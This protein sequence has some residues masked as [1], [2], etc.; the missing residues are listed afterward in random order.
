HAPG[1]M[2]MEAIAVLRALRHIKRDGGE[3]LRL[4][5]EVVDRAA[6]FTRLTKLVGESSVWRSLTPYLH[7]WHL[8]KPDMRSPEALRAAIL[9][10]L[11]R[12]WLA[13]DKELP[14]IVDVSE[15]SSLSFGGRALRAI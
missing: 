10:Q 9:E 1:G 12:E 2:S 8:K 4:M 6:P 3:P 11:R 15:L 14:E 13:R 7:P 5:L